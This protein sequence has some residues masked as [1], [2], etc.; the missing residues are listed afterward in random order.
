MSFLNWLGRY[1]GKLCE[2]FQGSSIALLAL[3]QLQ[4]YGVELMVVSIIA[5]QAHSSFFSDPQP[6]ASPAKAN[7]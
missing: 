2:F 5:K 7:P 6:P 3:P 4:R 1:G